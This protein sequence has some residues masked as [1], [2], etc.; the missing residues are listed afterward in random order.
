MRWWETRTRRF[1]KPFRTRALWSPRSAG[2]ARLEY[3]RGSMPSATP[4]W[5]SMNPQSP[6]HAEAT[7]FTD[8]GRNEAPRGY[9]VAVPRLAARGKRVAILTIE[10]IALR[11]V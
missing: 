6:R 1:T 4:G 7:G 2:T 5:R 9:H 8:I 10:E 3:Q 11:W